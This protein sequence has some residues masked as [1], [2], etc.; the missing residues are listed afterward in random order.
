[1]KY[2]TAS[3]GA[4]IVFCGASAAIV[5]LPYLIVP[6]WYENMFVV[7]AIIGVA[8]V[9]AALSATLSFR[10]TLRTHQNT[11]GRTR[12]MMRCGKCNE[13]VPTDSQICPM[14]GASMS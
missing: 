6:D 14:C 9:L 8:I 12:E 10:A 1:M 3:V 4:L 2:V 5:L 13:L 11:G 7:V